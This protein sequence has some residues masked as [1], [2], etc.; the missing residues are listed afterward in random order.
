MSGR[1]LVVDDIDTNRAVLSA[2]LKKKFFEVVEARTGEEALEL[3][4]TVQPDIALLDVMMPGLSG[5]D[6]CRI[7][8][9][10]PDL[11][12]VPVVIVT[13]LD[14]G[15]SRRAGIEA[16][17]DDFLTKPI[18][19]EA[20]FARIR[21]LLRMKAMT[22]ELRM[23][24]ETI[25]DIA[26][27]GVSPQLIEP[28]ENARVIG[29]TDE[30][31]GD[32]LRE[33][34]EARLSVKFSIV[35]DAAETWA[36][37]TETPPEAVLVDALGFSDFS[38]DFCAAIRQRPQARGSAIL[39]LL[40]AARADEAAAC[41]DAGAN[42]YVMQP[43]DPSELAA[44]LRTQL[45]HKAY[46]DHLRS[47][48]RDGLMMAVTDPLTGLRNRRYLDHHLGRMM[49]HARE[50]RAPLSLLAFDLDRFKAIND[51]YGHAA[52]DAVLKEFARRLDSNT[53]SVD[54]IART[55]GE[56]FLVAMPD[57]SIDDARIAAERVRRAVE[58]PVFAV[59]GAELSVTVSV[60]V[61][62]L[63]RSD[64]APRGLIERADAALYRAKH[65]G[66]NRVILEAA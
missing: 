55:G 8:K 45:R 39:A 21:S 57:A 14:D 36:A 48:M 66:R 43:I 23:R 59:D 50:S 6:G 20:L 32:I 41:L 15:S 65:S 30:R 38:P 5:F 61:A 35:N 62:A 58:K 4:K 42:D 19:A 18:I 47:S 16:G 63:R 25:R 12:H 49:E 33:I 28:P 13:T 34:L 56:E 22:D 10:D 40:D 51:T 17:A 11:A 29:V 1:I 7:M 46:A 31:S 52:G 9:A 37:L 3:A 60:G 44:R 2:L 24:D 54:L 64:R 27:E 53:R 26:L